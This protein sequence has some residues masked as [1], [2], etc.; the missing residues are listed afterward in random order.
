MKYIVHDTHY[1]STVHYTI[2]MWGQAVTI[3]ERDPAYPIAQHMTNTQLAK[4]RGHAAH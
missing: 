2:T 4:Q 3:S 1:I